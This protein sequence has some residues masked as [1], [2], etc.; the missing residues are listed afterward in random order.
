MWL[1]DMPAASGKWYQV[2]CQRLELQLER[3]RLQQAESEST[4]NNALLTGLPL[5]CFLF[6]F[7]ILLPS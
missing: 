4:L 1:L 5:S 7:V 3:V 6:L 2:Q